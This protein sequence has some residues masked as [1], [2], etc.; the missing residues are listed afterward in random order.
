MGFRI[1]FLFIPLKEQM[2][3][4]FVLNHHCRAKN[5]KK[6]KKN[7][8]KTQ[9]HEK[10]QKHGVSYFPRNFSRYLYEII[11]KTYHIFYSIFFKIY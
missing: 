2:E 3:V 8:K 6:H 5:T 4:F 10:T 7:T 1:F 9:K 11:K